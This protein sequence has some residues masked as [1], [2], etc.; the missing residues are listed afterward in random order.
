MFK[1]RRPKV[2]EQNPFECAEKAL[3]ATNTAAD[4]V[5]HLYITFLLLGTYI[6]LIVA[7]TTDEQ[8][9]RGSPVTLPLLNVEL[10]IVGFYI[11][12]PWL[13]VL[14]HLN[15]LLQFALL[16]EKL[17]EFIESLTP[18]DKDKKAL[19]KRLANFPLVQMM[20]APQKEK[21]SVKDKEKLS[22]KDKKSDKDKEKSSAKDKK[23]DKD[24]EQLPY[25]VFAL[26]V[27]ITVI[28]LPLGLLLGIHIRFLPYHN[29]GIAWE[30]LGAVLMDMVLLVYF[31]P[32]IVSPESPK[33]WWKNRLRPVYNWIFPATQESEPKQAIK[34][35]QEEEKNAKDAVL[36]LAVLSVVFLITV[37]SAAVALKDRATAEEPKSPIFTLNLEGQLL[38]DNN[39]SAKIIDILREH[40]AEQREGALQEIIGIDLQGRDLR[41]THL[42]G[43]LLP[44]ANLH[45][46]QLQG[47]VLT[48]ASLQRTD[49]SWANLQ[50]AD[51]RGADLRGADLSG[52]NLWGADLG[53]ADLRG[54]DL[55]EADLW[56]ALLGE[57]R[58]HGTRVEGA[59]LRGADLRG[60]QLQGADLG[61]ADLRGADLREQK[62]P[63]LAGTDLKGA[64]LRE[65][66]IDGA[67]FNAVN[68]ELA[69][70]RQL[71]REQLTEKQLTEKEKAY[72]E[73]NQELEDEVSNL[74]IRTTI[75]EKFGTAIE[76]DDTLK[77]AGSHQHCLSDEPKL[78][79]NCLT[80]GQLANY[81][82]ALV[83]YL[84][85]KLACRD[86]SIARGLAQR[87][88]NN[89]EKD[90]AQALLKN[91]ENCAAVKEALEDEH[92]RERLIR[93]LESSQAASE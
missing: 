13:L 54:T 90:L 3:E 28:I 93:L 10:P 23:S 2:S 76:R 37:V 26:I 45:K 33:E 38:I 57:K 84:L 19:Q 49:L 59:D 81:R 58:D 52:A 60:A 31:W 77:E 1:L 74:E 15:F 79:P 92:L 40:K 41:Y 48:R 69:D 62:F 35:K 71:K 63:H 9:L 44:K 18:I 12:I 78:L 14:V 32:Y 17:R 73:L 36:L 87:A 29:S 22:A 80:K 51:L 67:R 70:L 64:D 86:P 65:A 91:K 34:K 83:R 8:L 72:K 47:A 4:T 75:L 68:L 20:S 53:G 6:V 56:G 7:S 11:V 50:G 55:R 89:N 61:G 42:A 24:K 43:A 5:S 21:L 46:A 85:E 66:A 30:Q 82:S 88:Y 27:W 39:P 16:G 25:W